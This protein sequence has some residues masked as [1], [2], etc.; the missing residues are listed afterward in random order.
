L[1]DYDA[2]VDLELSIREGDIIEVT[3]TD[4]GAG[5][6]EGKLNGKVGQVSFLQKKKKKK[7][8]DLC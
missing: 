7:K 1:Y 8:R 4:V 2:A 5:W 6:W 3:N